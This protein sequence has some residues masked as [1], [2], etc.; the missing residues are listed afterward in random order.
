[1]RNHPDLRMRGGGVL[2]ALDLMG[3]QMGNI[4]NMTDEEFNAGR[5][6]LNALMVELKAARTQLADM[7]VKPTINPLRN[8]A[9]AAL[10]AIAS[11]AII[12]GA[13]W[14]WFAGWYGALWAW[15]LGR[16]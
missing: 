2:F 8:E 16:L 14:A 10:V 4:E 7:D 15:F 3:G 1:M 11:M 9:L 6:R 5:V 13:L 12:G